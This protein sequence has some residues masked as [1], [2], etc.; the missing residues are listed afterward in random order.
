MPCVPSASALAALLP[1]CAVEIMPEHLIPVLAE[2]AKRGPKPTGRTPDAERQ[3]KSR[4]ARRAAMEHAKERA[5]K[6][7]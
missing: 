6:S 1:G 5:R 2:P 3:R 7:V 4:A